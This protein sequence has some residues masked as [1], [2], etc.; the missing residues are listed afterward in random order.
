MT[1]K[2]PVKIYFE[3]S[4]SERI[5]LVCLVTEMN[6]IIQSLIKTRGNCFDSQTSDDKIRIDFLLTQVLYIMR[7]WE[8]QKSFPHLRWKRLSPVPLCSVLKFMGSEAPAGCKSKIVGIQRK[9]DAVW[10]QKEEVGYSSSL[11]GRGGSLMR[12]Q[13]KFK[14]AGI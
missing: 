2:P 8:L 14:K 3:Y 12:R 7:V 6:S 10:F 1:P 13:I 5:G 11:H 9:K 4:D